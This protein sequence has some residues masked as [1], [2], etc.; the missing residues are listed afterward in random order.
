MPLGTLDRTPPP[1]FR[2]GYSA[3]TKLLF[4]SSL[5]VFLMVADTRF[6]L[7]GQARSV[8][9]TVLRPVQLALKVPIEM[10]E[11]GQEYL[12]GLQDALASERAAQA[13][14]VAQADRLARAAQLERENEQLRSLLG[15]DTALQVRS[16]AAQVLYE[17]PDR[18]SRKVFID[19]GAT[20]GVAAGAPVVNHEGVFGQV[21]RVYAMSSEVTLL[22][23]KDAAIPVLN[24]RTSQRGV[25]F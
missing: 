23:D 5:A 20:H 13:K 19:R 10:W 4:F 8:L 24:R 6:A 18:F 21:T 9:A 7:V 3:L 1:F 25:A 12:L 11:G 16:V 15:L 17:A 2:Q 22:V 14:L